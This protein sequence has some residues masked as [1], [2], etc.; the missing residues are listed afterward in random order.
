MALSENAA[1]QEVQGAFVCFV[2]MPEGAVEEVGESLGAGTALSEYGFGVG[3]VMGR[4]FH[5]ALV[6]LVK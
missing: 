5:M 3:G 1:G 4:V 6:F 2:V